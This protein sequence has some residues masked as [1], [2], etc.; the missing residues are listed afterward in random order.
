MR[1][2][3]GLKKALVK[4]MMPPESKTARELSAEYGIAENSIYAWK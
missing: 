1:Y 4:K 2:S 3:E